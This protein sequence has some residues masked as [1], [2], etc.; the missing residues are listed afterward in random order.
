MRKILTILL[1]GILL[2]GCLPSEENSGETVAD[3]K[4]EQNVNAIAHVLNSEFTAPD[5]QVS[6]VL[7]RVES[8]IERHR[9]NGTEV[10]FE[11]LAPSLLEL[12]A[13][14]KERYS[15]YFTLKGFEEFAV[16]DSFA[17]H[18]PGHRYEI[19][20]DDLNIQQKEESPIAYDFSYKVTYQSND[21]ETTDYFMKGSAV[22]PTPGKIE[23]LDITDM[24]E[25]HNRLNEDAS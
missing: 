7:E 25:L 4:N 10:E 21:G 13:L 23:H 8:E 16:T 20:I 19:R 12:D 15:S 11:K 6:S 17:F 5:K 24:E 3:W 1:A 2:S 9:S 22:L 14:L 18:K